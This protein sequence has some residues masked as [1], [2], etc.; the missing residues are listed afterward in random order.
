MSNFNKRLIEL[1]RTAK[2]Q[3]AGGLWVEMKNNRV[4]VDRHRR[5]KDRVFKNTYQTAR[6]LEAQIDAAPTA[7]GSI[8]ISNLCDLY[9]DADK[10]K[11]AVAD[12]FGPDDLPS[13]WVFQLKTDQPADI[14]L[15]LLANLIREK[16]VIMSGRIQGGELPEKELA[17]LYMIYAWDK[18]EVPPVKEFACLV[19]QAAALGL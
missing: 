18:K 11:A 3:T 12:V 1:E 7:R 10:L 15:Q 6:W 5:G 8:V 19:K 17:A 14:N 16:T 2:T 4:R 9:P 13:L